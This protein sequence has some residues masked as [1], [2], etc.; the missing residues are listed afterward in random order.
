MYFGYVLF[1]LLYIITVNNRAVARRVK[2]HRFPSGIDEFE[3]TDG[4]KNICT[5]PEKAKE[6]CAKHGAINVQN[7]GE[8]SDHERTIHCRCNSTKSTFLL[9]EERCV[10]NEN[11]TRYIHG[12]TFSGRRIY[13]QS[14]QLITLHKSFCHDYWWL[15][16]K[17]HWIMNLTLSQFIVLFDIIRT[18]YHNMNAIPQRKQNMRPTINLAVTSGHCVY[19]S[20]TFCHKIN[21]VLFHYCAAHT[22]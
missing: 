12:G 13:L 6:F 3:V 19:N 10:N 9:H 15:F 11:I 7:T 16:Y 21:L 17:A 18:I 4:N 8:C 20:Q 22:V 14:L 2:V 1:I 5:A